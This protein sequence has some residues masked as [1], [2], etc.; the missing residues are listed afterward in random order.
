MAFDNKPRK[1]SN[2]RQR[3]SYAASF[4]SE[5]ALTWWQPILVANPEPPIRSNWQEFVLEL[6]R[7]FG[8]PDL[9]QASERALRSLKM[10][11][12]HRVNKYMI[13]F[14]EHATYTGWNDR[15]LYS[16]FKRGLAERLKDQLLNLPQ[17][18]DLV[19]LKRQALLC[20]DRYWERQHEKTTP[21]TSRA[22]QPNSNP[23]S[24]EKPSSGSRPDT[25]NAP[26]NPPRKDLSNIL[27]S[28]GKLTE[29]EKERRKAKGL[30]MYC[31]ESPDRHARECIAKDKSST[32]AA[33]RAIFT[34]SGEPPTEGSIEEII[35]DPPSPSEN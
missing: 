30:C 31:G 1:F 25:R 35:D 8:E 10:Q 17:A 5:I 12:H 34:I 14:S 32:T 22:R 16:E 20:D 2:D 15:A 4:L 7:Y 28:D 26:S 27:G 13:E 3:V 23:S 21:T 11:D 9:A 33:G 6:N 24:S 29:A 19:E 18:T